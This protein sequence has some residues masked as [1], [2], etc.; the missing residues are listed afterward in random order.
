M[1]LGRCDDELACL[2]GL[3]PLH[4]HVAWMGLGCGLINN[5]VKS[6]F[7]RLIDVI[8]WIVGSD[9]GSVHP[10]ELF[11]AREVLDPPIQ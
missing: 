6:H 10:I 11:A 2:D 1:G 9:L 3:S 4:P 8:Y 7:A 5:V